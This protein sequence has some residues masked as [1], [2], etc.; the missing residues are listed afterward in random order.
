MRQQ[1]VVD[2]DQIV[3]L[4]YNDQMY[5]VAGCKTGLWHC[6]NGKELKHESVSD[7]PDLQSLMVCKVKASKTDAPEITADVFDALLDNL[8]EKIARYIVFDL[9]NWAQ[10][11][12]IVH[13]HRTL[14]I[15]PSLAID[16]IILTP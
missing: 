8:N 16:R 6:D 13:D 1:V 12:F 3:R 14:K 15:A 4:Y 7:P 11:Y 9:L 10:N 2:D 5:T